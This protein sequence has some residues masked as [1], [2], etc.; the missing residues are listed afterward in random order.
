LDEKLSKEL[1]ILKRENTYILE[2]KS[3]INQT[4]SVESISNRL[5]Q[6][7]ETISGPEDKIEEILRSDSNKER[8]AIVT[9]TFSN[10]GT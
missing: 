8:K 10:S 3:S 7:Q 9:T 6:G 2:M 1:E 4:K 5:Y